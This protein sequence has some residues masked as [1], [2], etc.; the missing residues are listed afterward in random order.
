VLEADGAY[1][2]KLAW[3]HKIGEGDAAV[4]LERLRA[5]TVEALDSAVAQGLPEAGPRGGVIWPLRYFVR[6]AAWHVLDHAWEIEDR[7]EG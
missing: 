7:V 4:E 3:K 2:R 6:R 1:L 5:A